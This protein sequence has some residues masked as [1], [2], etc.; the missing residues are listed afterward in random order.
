MRSTYTDL[1]QSPQ[2]VLILRNSDGQ[3]VTLLPAPDLEFA[4][5]KDSD[6][7]YPRSTFRVTGDLSKYLAP[8]ILEDPK[9]GPSATV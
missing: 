7:L 2:I 6:F 1:Y 4:I 8:L 3:E 9:A 5:L